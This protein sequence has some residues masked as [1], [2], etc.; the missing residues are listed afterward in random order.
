MNIYY[1]KKQNIDI[2]R[3]WKEIGHMSI[4]PIMFVTASMFILNYTSINLSDIKVFIVTSIILA[5][6]YCFLFWK[7]SIN[8]SEKELVMSMLT[9]I[10]FRFKR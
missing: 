6:M 7:F 8:R 3:F 5:T 1:Y 2:P 4:V 9:P 10:I